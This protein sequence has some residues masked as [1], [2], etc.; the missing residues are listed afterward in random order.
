MAL[1]LWQAERMAIEP[2]RALRKQMTPQ[3]VKLWVRLRELRRLGFHFRRQSPILSY[4]VDFECRR[5]KLVVEVD[6]GQ[7]GGGK[8]YHETA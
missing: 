6:G 5:R 2:A 1:R 4:V 3:E 7:H 8:G